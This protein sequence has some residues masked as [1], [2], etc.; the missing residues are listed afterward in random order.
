MLVQAAPAVVAQLVVEP[1]QVLA[2]ALQV[3]PPVAV[4]LLAVAQLQAALVLQLVV[5]AQQPVVRPRRVVLLQP[6]VLPQQVPVLPL[7]R[8]QR[9]LQLQPRW[10][11]WQPVWLLRLWLLLQRPRRM[12]RLRPPPTRLPPPTPI[13][14]LANFSSAPTGRIFI[15]V[16]LHFHF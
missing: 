6:V 1:A 16:N 8:V 5:L 10:V 14:F 11:W 7:R 3:V 12:M 13:K 9:L 2:A 4:Q 15:P